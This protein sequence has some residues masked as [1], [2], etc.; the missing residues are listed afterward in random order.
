MRRAPRLLGL[1]ALGSL[2][3]CGAKTGLHAPDASPP[4]PD[5]GVLEVPLCIEV[6]PDA[7]IVRAELTLPVHLQVVDVMIL[8]DATASMDEEIDNVRNRLQSTVVPGARAAIPDAAFGLA[9]LGEF[10]L[11]PHGPREVRPYELRVPIT[12]DMVR[13][14]GALEDAPNW[15][16]HDFAEAQVES[17]YQVATG[18]GFSPYISPSVGCPLGGSGGVCFRDEAFHVVLLITDAPMHNGPPTVPPFEPYEFLPS[19]HG[20]NETVAALRAVDAVVIGLG[21]IDPGSPTPMPHLRA[22]AEDTGAVDAAGSPLA[23]NIGSTGTAVGSGIVDAIERLSD[24]VPLDV[25]AFVEDVAGD[26]IDARSLVSAVR[27]L[28]ASP[29]GSIG[30]ITSDQFIDVLPG[31]QVVFELEID[32][33]GI[34]PSAETLVIPARV[35]FRADR[36]SRLGT[37]DVVIL[38]PGTDGGGCDDLVD[39]G[40]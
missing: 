9:F 23:F 39:A 21:S 40:P 24:G 38:I 20:Y 22:L 4:S 19:P 33:S 34:P 26:A 29:M 7:G 13:V 18:A 15:G 35:T 27:P 11:L 8:L 25:D 14:Q 31:T 36:R 12:T 30:G 5:A 2:L 37:R 10:P 32:V 1:L 17:L 3:G 6:T 28:S 16:N